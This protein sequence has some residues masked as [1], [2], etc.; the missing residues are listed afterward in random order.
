MEHSSETIDDE[1]SKLEIYPLEKAGLK[2]TQHEGEWTSALDQ[3]VP[4][5]QK[6]LG[7]NAGDILYPQAIL[8]V[9]EQLPPDTEIYH[10]GDLS[11]VGNFWSYDLHT[12]LSFCATGPQGEIHHHPT[13]RVIKVGDLLE[14]IKNKS[15]KNNDSLIWT[16]THNV[17][18]GNSWRDLEMNF[19][20]FL[21]QNFELPPIKCYKPPTVE[22]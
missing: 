1:Y 13:I 6:Y 2:P 8:Y 21:G 19:T 22:L 16:F 14:F 18:G 4:L 15:K 9:M 11:F 12:A 3:M 5:V 17:G 7:K 20:N 10:G